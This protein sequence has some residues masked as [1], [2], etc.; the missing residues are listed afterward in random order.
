[1]SSKTELFID[2]NENLPEKTY[3]ETAKLA[4]RKKYA[5]FFTPFIIARLMA[6]W[7]CE[8]PDLKS[9]LDP[10]FGMGVFA[11]AVRLFNP[12]CKIKGIEIDPIVAEI[13]ERKFIN[14]EDNIIIE[15]NDYIFSDWENKYDGIICNPPYFK[16]HNYDNIAAINEFS[17]KI[18]VSLSGFTNLYALF[19]L[20]SLHQLKKGGRA[21]Y[22]IPSEFMNADYG[23]EIKTYLVKHGSLRHV[24]V[25]DFS[26]QIFED[27]LTTAAILF[28]AN[29]NKIA[30]VNFYSLKSLSD[31]AILEETIFENSPTKAID[32]YGYK[33][34][35]P[36]IKWRQYYQPNNSS[37][38]YRNLVPF[39]TYAKVVRGIAT[40]ANDFFV[41]NVSK[42]KRYKIPEVC[43]IPCVSRS[44]D[45]SGVFF[46]EAIFENIKKNDKN[47]YLLNAVQSQDEAVLS[48]LQKG[49]EMGID[50]KH[51]TANRKPWYALENRPPA[52]IWVGVFNRKGLKFI[53][54]ETKVRNLTTFHCIY[55]SLFLADNIELFFAYLLTNLSRKIFNENSREYGNGLQK[56]EPSDLNQSLVPDLSYISPNVKAE[57]LGIYNVYKKNCIDNVPD[58]KSLQNLDAVFQTIFTQ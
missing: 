56:F 4:H 30:D 20:K 48:Y 33:E 15:L 7:I 38:R 46:N 54:N 14:G 36:A 35:L 23:R 28:F 45:V 8:V 37:H 51:L 21:A 39:T 52:P 29:E 1:M 44:A 22:I 2:I 42:A 13:A 31:L 49:V 5:Q 10:A 55:P 27:V 25:F 18:N 58:E 32:N 43:L 11:R 6:R 53:R 17:Q 57:I 50:K 40:G 41:F 24:A 3:C 12:Y 47:I 19:L 26:N 9:V 16:F 34:L